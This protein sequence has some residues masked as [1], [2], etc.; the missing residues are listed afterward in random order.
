MNIVEV[1]RSTGKYEEVQGSTKKYREVPRST[2]KYQEV[3]G[4]TKKYKEVQGST[5]VCFFPLVEACAE[6][7]RLKK[8]LNPARRYPTSF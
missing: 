2:G 6:T 3:Q 8:M 7:N 1:R 5:E 4:S